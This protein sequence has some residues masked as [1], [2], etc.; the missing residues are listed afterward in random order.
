[1]LTEREL[2]NGNPF[3][4]T[5]A[6]KPMRASPGASCIP[7]KPAMDSMQRYTLT[8]PTKLNRT[9]LVLRN[10]TCNCR[11]QDRGELPALLDASK[12]PG[13]NPQLLV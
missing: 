13:D 2:E 1:M 5:Q 7:T 9:W 8:D 4:V 6:A 12:E 3:L 10:E 11:L